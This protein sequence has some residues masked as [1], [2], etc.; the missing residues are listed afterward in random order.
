ME[1][2]TASEDIIVNEEPVYRG[3]NIDYDIPFVCLIFTSLIA[4]TF[5]FKKTQKMFMM[6]K[7][8]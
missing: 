4:I 5:F 8:D 3:L 1:V 7:Q 2:D 6:V